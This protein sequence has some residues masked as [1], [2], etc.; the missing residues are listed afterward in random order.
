MG[1]YFS[2]SKENILTLATIAGFLPSVPV[3]CDQLP[4][5]SSEELC[6]GQ[7]QQEQMSVLQVTEVYGPGHVQR[8]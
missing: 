1:K 3:E 8:W 4:V 7:S 2:D 5:S 6:G